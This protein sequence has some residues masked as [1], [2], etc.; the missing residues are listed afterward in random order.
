MIDFSRIRSIEKLEEMKKDL[1]FFINK[2]VIA[3]VYEERGIGDELEYDRG[4]ARDALDKV[5]KQIEK[6]NQPI[7]KRGSKNQCPQGPLSESSTV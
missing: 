6:L 4:L 2:K 1:N 5:L 7:A 3:D